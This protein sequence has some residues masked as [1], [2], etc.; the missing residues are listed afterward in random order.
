MLEF[1]DGKI[2]LD[3]YH[4]IK[5]RYRILYIRS[6]EE[7]RVI[8]YFTYM[9]KSEGF[10]LYQWDYSRGLLDSHTHHQISSESSEVHNGDPAAILSH[11]IDHAKSDAQKMI[12]QNNKVQKK[13][14]STDSHIYMLLDFHHFMNGPPVERRLK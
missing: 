7:K 3:I 14:T 11:I 9:S 10:G 8:E 13:A 4:M 12:K 2:G 1:G 5:A 6:H